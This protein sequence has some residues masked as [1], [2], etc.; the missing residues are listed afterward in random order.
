MP[1]L[2]RFLGK[3]QK[4]E[5]GRQK[6]VMNS[7]ELA[8][9]WPRTSTILQ[10]HPYGIDDMF[11][12]WIGSK[13]AYPEAT[14]VIH[15][16][17]F[18]LFLGGGPKGCETDIIAS[19]YYCPCNLTLLQL[20]RHLYHYFLWCVI[21]RTILGILKA[22]N[23]FFQCHTEPTRYTIHCPQRILSVYIPSLSKL[24]V[25]RSIEPQPSLF[26]AQGTNHDMP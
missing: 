20:T 23:I 18:L 14:M 7:D 5:K 22:F 4:N 26:M 11:P 21:W 6:M 13:L 3:D 17:K 19:C 8:S 2:S 12:Q 15:F 24:Q 25:H 1:S 9:Q 16:L 10:N